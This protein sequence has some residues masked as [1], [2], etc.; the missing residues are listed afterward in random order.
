MIPVV[1]FDSWDAVFLIAGEKEMKPERHTCKNCKWLEDLP[2]T[3][4][5]ICG[6]EYSSYDQLE[7]DIENDSCEAWERKD[8][9]K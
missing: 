6:N 5:F 8:E 1:V 9:K 7:C 4:T 3:D 2:F